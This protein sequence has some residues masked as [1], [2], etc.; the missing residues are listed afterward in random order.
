MTLAHCLTIGAGLMFAE[1]VN[2]RIVGGSPW[3]WI[4]LGTIWVCTAAFVALIT[5]ISSQTQRKQV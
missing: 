4:M 1:A 2:Q 3:L 5:P